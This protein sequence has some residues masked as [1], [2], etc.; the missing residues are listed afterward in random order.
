MT[1]Y[2]VRVTK[3][4]FT[5]CP[6][7]SRFTRIAAELAA[8]TCDFCSASLKVE[9]QRAEPTFGSRVQAAGR[10]ALIAGMLASSTVFGV[11]CDDVEEDPCDPEIDLECESFEEDHSQS[12]YGDFGWEDDWEDEEDDDELIE[13]HAYRFV[14]VEDESTNDLNGASPGADI[15]AIGLDVDDDGT[16]DHWA[17]SVEDFNIGGADNEYADFVQVLGEPDAGCMAQNFTSLGGAGI[18][19]DNFIIVGFSNGADVTF[20]SQTVIHIWELG[21]T[22]CPGQTDWKDDETTVSISISS[23]RASFI[24]IGTVGNGTNAV[25]IP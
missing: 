8:T 13:D 25:I 11:A 1:T 23:D 3:Q 5:H 18:N 16:I 17:T 10:G 20:G 21:P 19:G 12:D 4:G 9:V 2:I 15:D 24:R 6:A 22:K 7:C 14:M